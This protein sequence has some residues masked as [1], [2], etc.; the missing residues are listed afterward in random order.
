[1]L[2]GKNIITHTEEQIKFW[3]KEIEELRQQLQDNQI[4]YDYFLE[5]FEEF[6]KILEEKKHLLTLMNGRRK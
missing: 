2:F 1:M 6:E 5:T 4:T 3:E